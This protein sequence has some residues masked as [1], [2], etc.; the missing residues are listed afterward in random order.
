M[1]V[2]RRERII[3][4]SFLIPALVLLV[5]F[6]LVPA[7]WAVYLS[8]TDRALT[9][10]LARHYDF[11]GLDNYVSLFQDP[12][13]YQS[14]WL[15]LIFVFLSAIVG[16][17]VLGLLAALLLNRKGLR[18]D[19][20]FSAAI[21]LPLVVPETI[22]AFAWGS[23]LASG[24]YGV[25]NKLIGLFGIAPVDWLQQQPMAAI[26]V[27]NIWRG[28]AFAMIIFLAALQGIQPE[29]LEAAAMDGAGAWERLV[30]ITL[31][32]LRYAI[33]LYMLLTTI[34]TFGIFGLV[35]ILTAGGPGTSTQILGIYIYQTSFRF[36]QLGYGSAAA[37]VTLL[38]ALALG[39][40]YVRVLQPE[41]IA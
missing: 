23:M 16:Q 39:L 7:L 4:L 5:G 31:P 34:F 25:A 29:I 32:L 18:A 33:L 13:F 21:L 17:F 15:T 9:G 20:L 30:H 10:A 41:G 11:V 2:H 28:I 14:L 27:M 24:T 1:F 19:A 37:V 6:L 38:I 35:Y 26:I 12:T 40:F 3:L 22:A 36:F 8:F